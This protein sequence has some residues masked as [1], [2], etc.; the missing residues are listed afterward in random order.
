VPVDPQPSSSSSAMDKAPAKDTLLVLQKSSIEK[1][2]SNKNK[3]TYVK[4][5]QSP[6]GRSGKTSP[7]PMN[8][9]RQSLLSNS[10]STENSI[11]S[12]SDTG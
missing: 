3:I 6:D 11:D 5:E 4:M 7:S 8:L 12:S 10:S 2:K 1:R 9:Q